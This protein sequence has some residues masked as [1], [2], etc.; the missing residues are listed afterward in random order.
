MIWILMRIIA[1]FLLTSHNKAHTLLKVTWT[2]HKEARGDW[3]WRPRTHVG[4]ATNEIDQELMP[5]VHVLATKLGAMLLSAMVPIIVHM[6]L[7]SMQHNEI[8]TNDKIAT[9]LKE[10]VIKP[11]IPEKYLDEKTIFHLNPFG[12][13]VI[14]G[15]HGD[16]GLT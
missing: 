13:F 16:V 11:M 10:H 3:C 9:D 1:R 12:R 8:I 15:P 5:L 2:F 6:V 4:Y 14:G 7:I